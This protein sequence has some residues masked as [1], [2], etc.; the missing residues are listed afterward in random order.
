M[1]FHVKGRVKPSS[2]HIRGSDITVKLQR[3][4][5]VPHRCLVFWCKFLTVLR[6]NW[7]AIYLGKWWECLHLVFN[8]LYHVAWQITYISECF[9]EWYVNVRAHIASF[10]EVLS[11]ICSLHFITTSRS[12]VKWYPRGKREIKWQCRWCLTLA[13]CQAFW[14]KH[15]N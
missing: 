3:L 7:I 5:C 14:W 2:S 8:Y 10:S 6:A 13:K 15:Q 1:L 12:L 11:W 9:H 4:Y